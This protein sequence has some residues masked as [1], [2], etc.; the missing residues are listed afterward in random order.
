MA[1]GAAIN[2]VIKSGTNS[3]RATGWGYK[4]DYDWRACNYFLAP[5]AAK[6]DG[7]LNQYGGNI[8]GPILKNKLFFFANSER[9]SREQIAPVRLFSLATDALRRGDFSGVA[10]TIYDPRR[11]L[12]RRCARRS[13]AT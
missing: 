9:T 11:I 6:P 1:G 13:P 2:V 10:A 7:Q 3:F 4:T 5:T 12:T 8:G